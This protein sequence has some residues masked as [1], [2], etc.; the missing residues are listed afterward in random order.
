MIHKYISRLRH[1]LYLAFRLL[2]TMCDK[3]DQQEDKEL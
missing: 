2:G 1:F 3:K